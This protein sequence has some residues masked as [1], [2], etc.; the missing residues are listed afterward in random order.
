M[1]GRFKFF[2]PQRQK[3]EFSTEHYCEVEG[4]CLS[5]KKKVRHD[6]RISDPPS[7][8]FYYHTAAQLTT[9]DPGSAATGAG[10]AIASALPSSSTVNP[11]PLGFHPAVAA[12]H[13]YDP[14]GPY[15]PPPGPQQQPHFAGLPIYKASASERRSICSERKCIEMHH[16][17]SVHSIMRLQI[18]WIF[19]NPLLSCTSAP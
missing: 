12:G 18:R 6:S 4:T 15:L 7:R 14:Y 9:P 5:S 2:D 10:G 11:P 16:R 1:V 8:Q 13:Y 19:G 17:P 3:L